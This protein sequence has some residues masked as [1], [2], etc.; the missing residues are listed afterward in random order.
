MAVEIISWSISMKVW[1]W[2]GIKITTPGSAVGLATDCSMG[3]CKKI[4][5]G[6]MEFESDSALMYNDSVQYYA[7]DVPLDLKP[8]FATL[9]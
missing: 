3:P 4:N 8:L 2:A 6:G 7:M 9:A 1:D 5:G